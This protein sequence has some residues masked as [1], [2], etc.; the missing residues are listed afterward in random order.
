MI[1]SK[2]YLTFTLLFS[3]LVVFSDSAKAQWNYIPIDQCGY[4]EARCTRDRNGNIIDKRTGDVYDRKGKLLRRG[5]GNRTSQKRCKYV[6]DDNCGLWNMNC[7][8]RY[9]WKC[10]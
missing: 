5:N 9:Y 7:A 1:Q 8:N 3:T 6:T 2:Y 10:S 4:Q